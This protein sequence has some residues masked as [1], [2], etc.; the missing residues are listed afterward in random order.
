MDFNK[1]RFDCRHFVGYIPCKPNKQHGVHCQ[2]ENGEVCKFYNPASI[3]ILIIKLGA[4][5]DV[6]RTT[7]LLYALRDK[8]PDAHLTWLTQ[9]PDLVPSAKENSLGVDKIL[10]WN[11]T[12]L[13][14][15]K[16]SLYDVVINLDK[17]EQ[18][19]ALVKSL[20]DIK[21]VFGYILK[22]NKPYPANDLA[23]HKYM[24]GIFDDVSIANKKNYMQETFEI[25]GFEYKLQQYILPA[26]DT[27]R[28]F[29]IDHSKKVVGLNTGCGGRWTSRLWPEEYWLDLIKGLQAFGYEVVILGGPEEQEKNQRLQQKTNAKYFGVM[30]LKTFMGLMNECDLI[31]SAVTMGMHIAIGL[32]KKL[33]LFNNIFN[34]N[35]F[36][37]FGR[38]EILEPEKPCQCYFT[39]KCKNEDYRCIEHI[40]PQRVLLSV[41]QNLTT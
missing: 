28:Q 21:N 4:A 5:G 13:T 22:D 11:E 19:C 15:V 29:E 34:K 3:N 9:F 2:E 41:N 37:L 27:T 6:I 10:G 39:P 24:T 18:A 35:E 30:P 1:I 12:S 17:D 38:G 36:E 16:N 20:G 8:Y 14:I 7:P 25:C 23:I 31:V 26:F 40:Y 33:I 32:K